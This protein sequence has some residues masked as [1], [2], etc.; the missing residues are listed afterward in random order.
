MALT[1]YRVGTTVTIPAGTTT[2]DH[3]GGR[4]IGPASWSTL[5]SETLR[6][7]QLIWADPVAGNGGASLLYTALSGAGANLVAVTTDA[8]PDHSAISN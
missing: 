4:T 6:R 3:G 5:V 8:D 2:A 7:G 1:R